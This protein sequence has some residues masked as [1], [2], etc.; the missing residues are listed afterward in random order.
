LR[1]RPRSGVDRGGSLSG[2]I[3]EQLEG[4][5]RR[6]TVVLSV[7]QFL[8]APTIVEATDLVSTLPGR[9]ARRFATRLDLFDL[10]FA[11]RGISLFAAWHPRVH[12]DPAH[13]WL[14]G[15]IAAV[16]TTP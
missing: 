2:F 13:V 16:A 10:P 8:L 7:H 1:A 3:D 9:L 12:A 14:R 5:G 4:L 6:R 15:E 11:A